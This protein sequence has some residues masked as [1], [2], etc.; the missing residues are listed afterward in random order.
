MSLDSIFGVELSAFLTPLSR[1]FLLAP[2]TGENF[3]ILS[4]D[5]KAHG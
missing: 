2:L 1:L 3:I 5:S 4:T